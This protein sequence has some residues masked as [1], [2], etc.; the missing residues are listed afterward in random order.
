MNGDE[1]DRSLR[2]VVAVLADVLEIPESAIGPADNLFTTLGVDS[3]AAIAVFLA[4]KRA[5]GVPEPA[6]DAQYLELCTPRLIADYV[7]QFKGRS[8]HR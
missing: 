7:V 3:L 1:I 2:Q 5:L 6:S 4:L 8:A